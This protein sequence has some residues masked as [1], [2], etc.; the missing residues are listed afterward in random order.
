MCT[1]AGALDQAHREASEAK[2]SVERLA[3][4]CS[5]FSGDL[6]RQE[7]MIR[8][9][10][11]V[12]AELRDEACTLWASGWLAFQHRAAKAFSGL[13]FNLQVPDEEEAEVSFSE[14]EVDPEVFPDVPS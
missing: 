12:I 3:K 11:G 6:Q 9:R 2:S 1:K 13:D 7:A 4:E 14:D 5:T 8:Q 10:D